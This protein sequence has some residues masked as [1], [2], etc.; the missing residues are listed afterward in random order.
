MATETSARTS[1]GVVV[2]SSAAFDRFAGIAGI[3]TGVSSLLYAVFFLL[4]KGA[5]HDLLPPL[6]LALGG[7]LAP[8]V[9]VALYARVRA[10]DAMFAAWALLLALLGQFGTALHGVTDLANVLAPAAH[11]PDLSTL[12]NPADPRGFSAF[13]VVGVA[14]FVFAWLIQRSGSLPRGLAY[15]GYALAVSLVA[16]FL[17]ALFGNPASSL[18]ILVPGGFASLIATPI[19]NIWLGALFLQRRGA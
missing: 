4:V 15:L 12:P 9:A 1:T 2:T 13:G 11:A 16:L 19:W 14:V 8:A 10:S 5:A 3:V 7:F 17:G 6:L 18:F